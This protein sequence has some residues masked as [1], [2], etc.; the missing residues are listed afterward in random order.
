MLLE[1]LQNHTLMTTE[2]LAEATGFKKRF[3][4]SRRLSGDSPPFIRISKSAVRY[5]W[6]DVQ[7]W[8]QARVCI[9]SPIE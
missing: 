2:Q 3:W 6:G 5:R 8:L 9:R 1:N 4:E 7:G